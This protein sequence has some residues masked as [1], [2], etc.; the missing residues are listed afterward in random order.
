MS[1]RTPFSTGIIGAVE[2]VLNVGFRQLSNLMSSIYEY[3]CYADRLLQFNNSGYTLEAKNL[4]NGKLHLHYKPGDINSASYVSV[5]RQ[6]CPGEY[7]I[8]LNVS[9]PRKAKKKDLK[10][11]H[12][13]DISLFLR[14]QNAEDLIA[15]GECKDVSELN[16]GVIREFIGY[17]EELKPNDKNP[18]PES[19]LRSCIYT[20]GAIYRKAVEKLH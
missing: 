16:L 2:G 4:I 9:I 17:R 13:P 12:A 7:K 8:F 1:G 20:Q 6:G 15:I 18:S 19:H 3:C 10:I 5:K 11:K 14:E